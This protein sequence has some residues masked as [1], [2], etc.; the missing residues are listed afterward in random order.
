MSGYTADIMQSKGIIQN[1]MVFVS[2]PIS[3]TDLIKKVREV[4]DR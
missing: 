4:L 3:P 1:G 2:K